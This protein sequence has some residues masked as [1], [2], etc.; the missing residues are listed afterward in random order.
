MS[1]RRLTEEIVNSVFR[2]RNTKLLA[3][4]LLGLIAAVTPAFA[5]SEGPKSPT[6]SANDAWVNSANMNAQD[7][8]SAQDGGFNTSVDKI[9]F[10]FSTVSGTIN[11]VLVEIDEHKTGTRNNTLVVN[12]LNAGTCTA[13]TLTMDATDD[14]TYDSLGGSSD[15]WSCTN[16]TAAGVN[17]SAFGVTIN[18]NKGSGAT[19]S[20]GTWNVD[21]VR[22]T[23]TYTPA[24]AR[25][26]VIVSKNFD[27]YE[28]KIA[29]PAGHGF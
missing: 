1:R 29:R 2:T 26:R 5:D 17:N 6:A 4:V 25:N 18:A 22:I 12:L 14:S 10:G 28:Q 19:P 8:T 15:T 20:T 3:I 9:T 11:G 16:L 13:K 24:S 23:V 7:G 21:H 27:P